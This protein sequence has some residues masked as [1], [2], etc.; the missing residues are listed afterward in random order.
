[1]TIGQSYRYTPR[2]WVGEIPRKS[3]GKKPAV[4]NIPPP[5][6][7]SNAGR[8]LMISN[9]SFSWS[10]MGRMAAQ[11]AKSS[12]MHASEAFFNLT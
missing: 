3:L 11:V 9:S 7:G 2:G 5:T 10:G 1:M 4:Q 8:R 12:L 6:F